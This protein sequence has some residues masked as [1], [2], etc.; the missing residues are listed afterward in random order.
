M[1]GD[2]A[3]ERCRQA[4]ELYGADTEAMLELFDPGVVV[5]VAPPNF[6]SGTY[7]GRDEYA[8]LLGRWGGE[9]DE[10]RI[11]VD[12]L[13][14]EGEW[15]LARVTY[16]GR[17]QGSSVEIQQPSWELSEWRDGL[18]VRYEVYWDGEQGEAAF[19]RRRGET[20]ETGG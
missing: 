10:M 16:H 6:E 8:A 20:G 2:T 7:E 11:E 17:G 15:V 13:S 9:W 18:C 4:Y 19:A 1:G 14:Q 5:Y 3:I 12:E